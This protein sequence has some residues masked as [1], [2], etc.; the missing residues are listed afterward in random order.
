MRYERSYKDAL[1]AAQKRGT[2]ASVPN[3]PKAKGKAR[4]WF[5]SEFETIPITTRGIVMGQFRDDSCVAA[6]ARML[7]ADRGIAV[8]ESYLRDLL[9]IE[10]GGYLSDLPATL[11]TIGIQA[12]HEYRRDLTMAALQQAVQSGVAVVYLEKPLL[13]GHAVVVEAITEKFVTVRDPLPQGE[14]RGYQVRQIDFLRFWLLP[15]SDRG[16]AVIM[17]K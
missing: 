13:G 15:D 3:I 5:F 14:G 7:A 6:C 9:K 17:V 8:P 11:K 4:G 10:A 16:R 12:R 2:T 1:Q